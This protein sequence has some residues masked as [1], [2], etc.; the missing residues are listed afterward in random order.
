MRLPNLTR[1][2]SRRWTELFRSYVDQRFPLWSAAR[3][4]DDNRQLLEY[5]VDRDFWR[6]LGTSLEAEQRSLLEFREQG[7]FWD[8]WIEAE[9]LVSVVVVTHARADLLLNRCLPSIFAQDYGNIEVLVGCDNPDE[10]TLR[11]IS[12]VKDPRLRVA[13]PGGWAYPRGPQG[14]LIAGF[15]AGDWA[16]SEARGTFLVHLDD[17]DEML[18]G[19][20]STL[21]EAARRDQAELVVHAVQ[22]QT[23]QGFRTHFPTSLVK[24][25]VAL[26]NVMYHR[27]FTRIPRDINSFREGSGGDWVLIRRM[28]GLLPRVSLVDRPLSRHYRVNGK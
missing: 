8:S 7:G 1:G 19:R 28:L 9:P 5:M 6:Y 16:L 22:M 15:N 17:D 3:A 26:N 11:A 4:L 18:V 20:I 12:G 23:V 14:K 27:Y 24:G 13:M 10:G 2:P 25:Q 21:V